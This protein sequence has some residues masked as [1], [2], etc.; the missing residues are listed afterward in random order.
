[1]ILTRKIQIFCEDKEFYRNLSYI[2]SFLYKVA[3]ETMAEYILNEFIQRYT[4]NDT[5]IKDPETKLSEAKKKAAESLKQIY[6][7]SP[8]N[9]GYRYIADKC[10]EISSYIRGALSSNVWANFREDRKKV[11]SGERNYRAYKKGIPIPFIAKAIC[12]L[13]QDSFEWIGYSVGFIFGKDKKFNAP[14]IDKILSGEYSIRDS[15]FQINNKK[16]FLLL[17]VDIPE[18]DAKLDPN[19]TAFVDITYKCPVIITNSETNENVSVGNPLQLISLRHQ[20]ERRFSK[21][22]ASSKFNNG[23]H[24]R[25]QKLKCWEV[26]HEKEKN[27]AKTENHKLTKHIINEVV[28]MGAGKIVVKIDKT[29][30]SDEYVKKNIV[31]Y[32]GY[33]DIVSKL[34]YKS[35]MLGIEIVSKDVPVEEI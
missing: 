35:K 19:K 5:I 12:N 3:N 2:N 29:A 26:F 6:Q 30:E 11:D 18:S 32:F 7:T 27:I 21:L 13:K 17:C 22:Q 20:L 34:E 15:K 23:G 33:F 24:G 9:I 31:R 14:I 28:R 16:V 25:K 8:Q 10:P 1:M 4:A